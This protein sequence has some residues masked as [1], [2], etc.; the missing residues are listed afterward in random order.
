M[1][2]GW[3]WQRPQVKVFGKP[4]L[5]TRINHPGDDRKQYGSW[6]SGEHLSNKEDSCWPIACIQLH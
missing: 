4:R 5:S 1:Q 2:A 3:P 6:Q